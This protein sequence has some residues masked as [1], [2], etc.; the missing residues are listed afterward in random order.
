MVFCSA[1]VALGP[2]FL[3][4]DPRLS[5]LTTCRTLMG[6]PA[7]RD[8]IRSLVQGAASSSSFP[9]G[10]RTSPFHVGDDVDDDDT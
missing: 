5:A 10:V 4:S 7:T 2:E 3:S 8:P 6:I 1:S 9:F